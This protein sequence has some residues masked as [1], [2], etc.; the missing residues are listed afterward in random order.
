ME[1]SMKL[2]ARNRLKGSI[3]QITPG[4]LNSEVVLEVAPGV[5]MV[6]MITKASKERLGLEVGQEVYAVIKA[7]HIML[8]LD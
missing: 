8:G 6:A 5:E 2:S 1:E 3:K 7:S 4:T